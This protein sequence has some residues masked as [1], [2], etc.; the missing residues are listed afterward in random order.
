MATTAFFVTTTLR[1]VGWARPAKAFLSFCLLLLVSA[2]GMA[3]EASLI[4]I[5]K[6]KGVL[7]QEEAQKLR[8][9]SAKG[10]A[11][12]DDQQALIGLLKA[13]GILN[14]QDLAKLNSPT[15]TSGDVNARLSRLETQQQTQAEQQAKA[16]EEL[17]KTTV[18]DVKKSVDWLNRFSFFGDIRVRHEGFYQDHVNSRNRQRLRLRF[19]ARLTVS[20][21]LEGG[22]RLV[23]GDPNEIV[24][25]N[26]TLTDVFTRKPINIDNAYVTIRPGKTLGL[27]KPLFSLTAGKFSVPFFRP[28]AV[29][30]SE[31]I[32]DEDLTPE[33]LS[34]E[35]TL[36]E[37]QAG[38]VMRSIK[39]VAGQW[40]A[41][42]F[43]EDR[44]AFM[45]G[46]Q[47]QVALAPTAK[48]QVTFA[49][50]DYYF[51][52]SDA[53]AQE[54]NRN[55]QLS[56]TN[57]VILRDGTVVKGGNVITPSSQNPIQRFA[58]G[59]HILNVGA[60]LAWDT[61][62]AKWP[63]TLMVDV[64][65][66]FQSKFGDDN[67]YLVGVGLGQT[68]NPGDWAVSALWTRVETDSVLSMFTLSDYGRR[69]GTNVQ[70]PIAKLDYM[71]LPR[72]TLTAK[73]YFVNL[74][75]RPS[76]L[77]NSTVNRVQ[78]DALFAF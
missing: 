75:D 27:E 59:F 23:S 13:K 37:G 48:T 21:E 77:T 5:L 73:G 38:D 68:R 19:G 44:D 76:G 50:A 12:E 62:Y 69:G 74:I 58:G 51:M 15:V 29:M 4:D 40:A 39:L 35:I 16:V 18:A 32:F 53:L 14:D 42:E 24:A 72:L 43:A 20:D 67:A 30:G 61:G 65:H 56:M 31:M 41:K 52:R 57:S 71:L 64:A 46:E 2:P 9:S 55:A 3:Q 17:K 45:L 1:S 8:S 36:L 22:L 63:F 28:R 34:E 25:N 54:R 70:G 60:Q 10:G 26:Q 78:F 33:G 11:P 6:A 49:A 7:S 47:I 66:N